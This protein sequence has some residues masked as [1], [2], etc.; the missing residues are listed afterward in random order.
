MSDESLRV[1]Y[2][3]KFD[4]PHGETELS[5]V[6][7]A[8]VIDFEYKTDEKL[9]SVWWIEDPAADVDNEHPREFRVVATGQP[10]KHQ[11]YKYVRSCHIPDED[12]HTVWHLLER[13]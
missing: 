2:R 11:H 3:H 5:L 10:W 6:A 4:D 1:V 13:R 12:F 9:F 7:G 8:E